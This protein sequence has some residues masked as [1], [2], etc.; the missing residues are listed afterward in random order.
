M[1]GGYHGKTTGKNNGKGKSEFVDA[2]H[3]WRMEGAV[4]DTDGQSSPEAGEG[5]RR[6]RDVEGMRGREDGPNEDITTA[7]ESGS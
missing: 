1:A 5:G 7:G 2:G 3:Q 4:R 6:I